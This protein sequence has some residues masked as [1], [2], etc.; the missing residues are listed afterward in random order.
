MNLE[1]VTI[2]TE[3]L[4]GFTVD[5]NSAF[6]G[7]A[8]AAIGVRIARR[9]SVP[10]TPSDAANSVMLVG[11]ASGSGVDS[12]V[13]PA[14]A[15]FSIERRFNPEE[16]LA[17]VKGELDEIVERHRAK[18]VNVEVET[19]QE[20]EACLSPA[21]API[22]RVLGAVLEELTGQSPR[23][24]LCP[25]VLETRFFSQRGIPGYGYGPG[26][27]AVSHGSEEYVGLPELFHCTAAYA[28]TAARLLA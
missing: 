22:G 14:G 11:G 8:L 12:N 9:T 15:W 16:T 24:E 5:T 28:L 7:Q 4:L 13:V 1:L 19:L 18:G 20:S 17:Q 3:L 26:L 10:T 23:F 25:G 21:D 2:G 6:L 27:L